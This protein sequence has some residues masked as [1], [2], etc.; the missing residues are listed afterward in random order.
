MPRY[1]VGW[2]LLPLAAFGAGCAA[3]SPA[4][5]T[6]DIV[7]QVRLVDGESYTYEL[8]N[9]EGDL[10]GTGVLSTSLE[11]DRYVLEQRYSRVGDDPSSAIDSIRVEVDAATLRPRAGDRVIDRA[12]LASGDLRA[13]SY[14]WEYVPTEDGT[15][16]QVTRTLEP[17]D[18]DPRSS[19]DEVEVRDHYYDNESSLWVWRGL[20]FAV[21]FDEHY[22]SANPMEGNQQTVNIRIAQ[23]ETVDVPAGTF[24]TW[25]I[26]VRTGRAVRTAW[27]NAEAPH[28]IV[29]WDNG[30]EIFRLQ[31]S[32]NA[33]AAAR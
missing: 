6:T 2:L 3:A 25:R 11:G 24:E 31:E 23:Q 29:Q 21:D 12:A 1:I 4:A 26:L 27:I 33:R 15:E 7:A 18:G 14:A 5:E 28:Q 32:S 22:V 8:S 10:L 20:P 19:T 9:A 16:L 13:E 17:L 30:N